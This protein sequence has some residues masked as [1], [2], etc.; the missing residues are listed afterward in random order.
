MNRSASRRE[1]VNTI[2]DRCRRTSSSTRSSTAGQ[3]DGLRV[4][5]SAP[6][7]SSSVP[8]PPGSG[9]SGSGVTGPSGGGGPSSSV[10][11]STGTTTRISMVLPMAGATTRTGRVP[12]RNALTSS[13]GRTVADSPMRWAG[14]GSSSSRRSRD[15]ARWAP[16]LV[17]ATACTSSTMTVSTPRSDSRAAEVSSRNSDSGVVTSTSG[18]VRANERRS[19]AGVSPVRMPT[20][21]PGSA[22]PSRRAAWPMPASGARRLRC[23]STASALSGD[24]YSTRQ[25]RVRSA[26]LGRVASRSS[27]HRNAASVLP[28]PVGATTSACSPAA[29]ADQAPACASVGAANAPVN[30]CL[31]AGEN[32]SSTFELMKPMVAPPTDNFR[33]V[34]RHAA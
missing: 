27:A 18:G 23:T 13:I 32:R 19:S 8:M 14:A 7:I 34:R 22:R 4:P 20:V 6:V 9:A 10:M 11:S 16:R 33:T 29:A 26:G 15:S 17:P 2:V 5:P 21:M 1:L 24:T 25:R 30:H 12:A 3:I 31:V 28:D